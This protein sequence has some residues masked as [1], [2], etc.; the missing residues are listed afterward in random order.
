MLTCSQA[1]LQDPELFVQQFSS[2]TKEWKIVLDTFL[3]PLLFYIGTW[4]FFWGVKITT[5]NN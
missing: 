1:F 4:Y 2:E 3:V 5:S